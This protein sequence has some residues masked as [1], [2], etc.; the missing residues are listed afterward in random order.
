MHGLTRVLV[1]LRGERGHFEIGAAS[2]TLLNV[3]LLRSSRLLRHR[4]R[5]GRAVGGLGR[6]VPF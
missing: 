4:L 1:L 2:D 5:V 6:T 3:I